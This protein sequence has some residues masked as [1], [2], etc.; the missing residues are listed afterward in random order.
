MY[1]DGGNL[2]R[3]KYLFTLP[4]FFFLVT[5]ACFIRVPLIDTTHT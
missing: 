5:T 2:K 3:K 4:D 1:D